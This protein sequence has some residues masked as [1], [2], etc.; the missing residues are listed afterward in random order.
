MALRCGTGS[1]SGKGDSDPIRLGITRGPPMPTNRQ[2][3]TAVRHGENVV[4]FAV[5]G[6]MVG[7]FFGLVL[8]E[9]HVR[10]AQPGEILWPL[11]G[12]GFRFAVVT[13]IGLFLGTYLGCLRTWRRGEW[14]GEDEDED[15]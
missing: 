2:L 13:L 12:A 9:L 7:G 15:D 3:W 5:G 11:L 10:K 14:R 4:W 8:A 6:V 1:I